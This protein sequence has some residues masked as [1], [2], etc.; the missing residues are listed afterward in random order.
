MKDF[1]FPFT[2]KATENENGAPEGIIETVDFPFGVACYAKPILSIIYYSD[3]TKSIVS[4][5]V[6]SRN[7]AI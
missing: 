7:V 6:S 1:R 5:S 3:Y 2:I 4:L